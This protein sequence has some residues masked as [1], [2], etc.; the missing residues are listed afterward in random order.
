VVNDRVSLVKSTLL[1]FG[2]LCSKRAESDCAVTHPTLTSRR[3]VK[4]LSVYFL[5]MFFLRIFVIYV[6]VPGYRSEGP[7][8]D[9]QRYQIF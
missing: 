9:S 2:A 3:V 7:G 4:I 6:R 8:F 1:H 5:N